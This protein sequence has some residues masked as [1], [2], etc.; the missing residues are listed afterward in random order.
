MSD[1]PRDPGQEVGAAPKKKT[2]KQVPSLRRPDSTLLNNPA[3]GG[4]REVV[5]RSYLGQGQQSAS[6]SADVADPGAAIPAPATPDGTSPA[7]QEHPAPVP[8]TAEHEAPRP[9][10]VAATP[11]PDQPSAAS[12]RRWESGHPLAQPAGGQSSGG[13]ADVSEPAP[14]KDP[15]RAQKASDTPAPS[16]PASSRRLWAQKALQNSWTESTIDL[17]L[18][19]KEWQTHA[20]RFTPEL[21]TALG[22]RVAEDSAATGLN[23]TAAHYVDAAM[24]TLLPATIDE[25]MK[26][27]EEFLRLM[28]AKK[29]PEGKQSSYRVSPGVYA[30]AAPLSNHLKAAGRARTAYHIYAAVLTKY[31][32]HLRAEGPLSFEE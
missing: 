32:E 9:D 3:L 5:S 27:A 25:Q 4:V 29:I 18:R 6:S 1:R 30:I 2:R 17:K 10:V 14:A 22:V 26:L 28:G 20:F 15:A 7:A 13:V 19:K 11:T 24:A 16:H 21:I 23:F 31:L 12:D 8:T